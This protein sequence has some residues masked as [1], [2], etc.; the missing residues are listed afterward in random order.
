MRLSYVYWKTN[1]VANGTLWASE[2]AVYG[3]SN[4]LS[5]FVLDGSLQFAVGSDGTNPPA[6]FKGNIVAGP[7]FFDA[8]SAPGSG[9]RPGWRR[10]RRFW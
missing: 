4:Q 10:F 5:R 8:A 7:G 6:V 9:Q 3:P 1:Q 2:Y